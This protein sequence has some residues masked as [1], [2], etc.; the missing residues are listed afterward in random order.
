MPFQAA[1]VAASWH[2]PCSTHSMARSLF[3]LTV[4]VPLLAQPAP[5]RLAPA[6]VW[7]EV[8]HT[9]YL[10]RP[11]GASWVCT[12]YEHGTSCKTTAD[13]AAWLLRDGP[14]GP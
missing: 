7:N 14:N 4:L 10:T 9:V 3:L 13:V 12:P 6:I 8:A 11:D 5:R 1:S 2:G